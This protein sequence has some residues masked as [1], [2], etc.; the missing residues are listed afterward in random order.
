[1]HSKRSLL[2]QWW[3]PFGFAMTLEVLI[4]YFVRWIL[5][6]RSQDVCHGFIDDSKFNALTWS[7]SSAGGAVFRHTWIRQ[8]PSVITNTQRID[9]ALPTIKYCL[10]KV[11]WILKIHEDGYGTCKRCMRCMEQFVTCSLILGLKHRS[12]LPWNL[13]FVA[14]FSLF[15][16]WSVLFVPQKSRSKEISGGWNW[17]LGRAASRSCFVPTLDVLMEVPWKSDQRGRENGFGN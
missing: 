4:V 9:A 12:I 14:T 10:D 8:D 5:W 11:R 2:V 7:F 15:I 1:M 17:W 3:H 6:L 16:F 13:F